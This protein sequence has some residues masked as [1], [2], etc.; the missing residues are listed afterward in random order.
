MWVC[1]S[2]MCLWVLVAFANAATPPKSP[3]PPRPN[4][5]LITL[6]TTRADR[7][8]FLGSERGLTPNLDALAK[9]S[10]VFS[11]AYSHVPLTP[12]SHATILTSTY[13]QFNHLQYMGEPLA[14]D[15]PYLPDLLRRRGYRT[16]AFVGSMILDPK[17]VTA[18]GFERG[19]DVYSAGFHKR[20][21][22]EDR[23]QS[24]ERRASEVVDRALTW[25]SKQ[26][27]GPFFL[28]VHCY[29]PHAPYEPPEPF[30]TRFKDPYDG[31]IAYTDAAMGKLFDALR[32]RGLYDN[33]MITVTADHGEAFGEHGERHHGIFLYDETIHVPLLIKL[34]R[35]VSAGRRAD[36]R[37][38]LVDIAPTMLQ[39]AG[40]SVPP[41]MQ[42]ESLL[43][44][45]RPR[46]ESSS[47]AEAKANDRPAYGE[48]IYAHRAFGWSVLRSWRAGKYL[49]VQAPKRELYDQAT[50]PRADNNVETGSK[51]VADTLAGQLDGFRR[52]TSSTNASPTNLAPEQAENLRALGYLP[53]S[54][55][56]GS[57]GDE[58]G[59][60]PKEHIEIANL[61]TEALFDAQDE[62]FEEAIPK[63]EKV[64]AQEPNT[65][66]AYL[67]LGRAYARLK[68]FERA[69][70]LL[71]IAVEKLPED[72]SAHYELGKALV[73]TSNWADAAPQFE[74]A[75]A[76]TRQ[77]SA[78]LHFYLA[79]VYE[80]TQQIP[81]AMKEF[82]E[83]IRLKP[84]HFRANLLL[85]RLYGMQGD[86][87]SAL[88][89]LQKAANVD[90]NSLEVHMFLANVYGKLGQMENERRERAEAERLKSSGKL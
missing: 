44:L 82:Q 56:A 20:K 58:G 49:Y 35:E 71:K 66:L 7:M 69:V 36:A 55:N 28:W 62:R 29:D 33:T 16:G 21:K 23:Y 37:V 84:D 24:V 9:Q 2:V 73:E 60:D 64:L 22:G 86:A 43:G 81:Q 75:I 34:P 14:K 50:D 68:Q 18:L 17:N 26:P 74:A 79:V 5:I 3:N 54:G 89:Y 51:A 63:L 31:E 46:A 80:R 47:P 52:K 39:G 32:A 67:E 77:P 27:R 87:K 1:R 85:G 90:S 42:G 48:T 88:P 72:G 10:V 61:L 12:P 13:P 70:P 11:R 57:Q 19:F 25:L 4:L 45:M 40:F 41:A 53:S 6:D 59:P 15:L 76:H 78:E 30:N 83:T 38:R 8:G 65:S